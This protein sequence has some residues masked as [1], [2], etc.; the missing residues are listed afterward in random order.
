MAELVVFSDSETGR[1]EGQDEI[2]TP[3]KSLTRRRIPDIKYL[4]FAGALKGVKRS[5]YPKS[6]A[7]QSPLFLGA[8]LLRRHSFLR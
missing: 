5:A 1:N 3:P 2:W 8:F 6:W 4:E 7:R